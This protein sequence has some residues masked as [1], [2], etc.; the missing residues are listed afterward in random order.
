MHGTEIQIN[1]IPNK[2]LLFEHT[3]AIG[4]PACDV[5]DPWRHRNATDND[6]GASAP[7]R[8]TA[9]MHIYGM[10]TTQPMTHGMRGHCIEK[11][12]SR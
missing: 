7:E 10:P 6:L 3:L 4:I 12:R 9:A 2:S 5:T 1:A 11:E 8:T